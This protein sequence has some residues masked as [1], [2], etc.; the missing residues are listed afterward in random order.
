[1]NVR[2]TNSIDILLNQSIDNANKKF[3][4]YT[5]LFL[6]DRIHGTEFLK[7]VK[8]YENYNKLTVD[9]LCEKCSIS[10]STYYRRIKVIEEII[11]VLINE[12]KI[13]SINLDKLSTLIDLL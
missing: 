12:I 3:I 1:M 7:I 6:F 8:L 10:L 2:K 11:N 4:V 9:E 13:V 5:F